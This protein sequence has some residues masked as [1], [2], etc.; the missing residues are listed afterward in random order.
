M[1]VDM[2]SMIKEV[3][4]IDP[5]CMAGCTVT[6]QGVRD[7][8]DIEKEMMR[9][10][11]EAEALRRDLQRTK[12]ELDDWLGLMEM[13]ETETDIITADWM[14]E[15]KDW[16]RK[17]DTLERNKQKEETEREQG[18]RREREE[19]EQMKEE[20]ERERERMRQEKEEIVTAFLNFNRKFISTFNEIERLRELERIREETDEW[21]LLMEL[22]DA[23]I[24]K[25]KA[26]WSR[27]REECMRTI[28]ILEAKNRKQEKEREETT[29][30]LR[31]ELEKEWAKV[32]ED[33]EAVENVR[34]EIEREEKKIREAWED[35]ERARMGGGESE[36]NRRSIKE[37]EEEIQVEERE[38][39]GAELKSE[40]VQS[41]RE[42]KEERIREVE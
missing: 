8:E 11:E 28:A 39:E 23:E 30:G 12:K 34:K 14:R 32:R 38:L 16:R 22:V 26:V 4:G 1:E 35:L 42:E 13:V 24:A 18:R 25:I 10:G 41:E 2:E 33:K 20:V 19:I 36:K 40:G 31:E 7:Q 5:D 6:G 21:M 15:R 27:E 17:M 3:G 37:T 29:R 9:M